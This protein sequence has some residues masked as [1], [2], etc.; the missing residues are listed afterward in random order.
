MERNEYDGIQDGYISTTV[1]SDLFSRDELKGVMGDYFSPRNNN[2]RNR[3]DGFSIYPSAR[4]IV[5]FEQ[6]PR[7]LYTVMD[8]YQGDPLVDVTQTDEGYEVRIDDRI[9]TTKQCSELGA[10]LHG[11]EIPENG[12]ASTLA[13]YI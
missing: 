8:A 9:L 4:G 2:F 11:L 12:Q 1:P 7:T 13:D 10:K 5:G 3:E 6:G